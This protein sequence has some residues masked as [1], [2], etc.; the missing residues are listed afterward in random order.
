M[1]VGFVVEC[2]PQGAESKVIPHLARMI[3]ATLEIVDPIPLK[4]K[5]LLKQ[6]CGRWA[7]ALLD[8][9]CARVLIICGICCRLGVN[10]K[11][12]GVDMMTKKQYSSR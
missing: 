8:L 9:G 4:N 6:D 10:M 2:G 11:A 12:V 7:K 1:R 5:Q 3:E